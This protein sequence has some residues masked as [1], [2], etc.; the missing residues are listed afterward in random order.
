MKMTEDDVYKLIE[1]GSEKF[2][3][4]Y[5]REELNEDFH[6][7][8]WDV[9]DYM[10]SD[11]GIPGPYI[12]E[13][14]HISFKSFYNEIDKVNEDYKG[15]YDIK[16]A[17]RPA[18]NSAYTVRGIAKKL[19]IKDKDIKNYFTL[20][21]MEDKI[22][23]IACF[24]KYADDAYMD[25]NYKGEIC[26]MFAECGYFLAYQYKVSTQFGHKTVLQFEPYYY[27]NDKICISDDL[28]HMT[29]KMNGTKIGSDGFVASHNAPIL[30]YPPRNYFFLQRYLDLM[31]GVMYNGGKVD[32]KK[33]G[34]NDVILFQIDFKKVK[35][36]H[37][38]TDPYYYKKKRAVYCYDSV[39]P[40]T[41]KFITV[42][43]I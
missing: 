15:I 2:R 1:K 16:A 34:E 41:I 31:K 21:Y 22:D 29:N 39:K 5:Y 11:D 9:Y 26:Q 19:G 8:A 35:N 40:N 37:F 17:D 28:Y 6:Y 43:K 10:D 23:A 30:Q 42:M 12:P 33:Q 27:E 4:K 20:I 18:V 32:K 13:E 36:I 38:Y 24:I 7:R 3:R 14:F 25:D